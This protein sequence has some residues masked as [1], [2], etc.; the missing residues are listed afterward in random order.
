MS[1]V[2]S[3][4]TYN[5]FVLWFNTRKLAQLYNL[6]EKGTERIRKHLEEDP[7]N[8]VLGTARGLALMGN[9]QTMPTQGQTMPTQGQ[10]MPAQGQTMPAQGQAMPVQGQVK[11]TQAMQLQGLLHNAAAPDIVASPVDSSI[12][13][14]TVSRTGIT[15]KRFETRSSGSSGGGSSNNNNNNNNNNH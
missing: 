14:V 5:E 6:D 4:K 2:D 8:Y 9:G 10:T 15:V 11:P 7:M 3:P 1:A 12:E 13:S